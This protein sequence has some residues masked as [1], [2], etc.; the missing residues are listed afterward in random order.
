MNLTDKHRKYKCNMLANVTV[1]YD[2]SLVVFVCYE[3]D[4][5]ILQISWTSFVQLLL[6]DIIVVM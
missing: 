3:A 4:R 5:P 1:T 6:I 2:P